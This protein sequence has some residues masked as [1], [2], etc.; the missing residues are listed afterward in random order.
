VSRPVARPSD[1]S[2]GPSAEHA[3]TILIPTYNRRRALEVVWPSYFTSAHVS[4][5]V[6]VDDGSDDGTADAARALAADAPVPVRVIAHG[7]RRGQQAAR[8]SAVAAARTEW[9]LF[10]EDDVWLEPDYLDTLVATARRQHADAVA[11]RLLTL[12][13]PEGFDPAAAVAAPGRWVAPHAFFDLERLEADFSATTD[14]PIAA[15]FLHSIA[16]IR[17]GLIEQV[18]FDHWYR[19]NGWREETDFYF[20]ATGAGARILFDPTTACH[21]LRGPIS[22][23]GGQRIARWRVEYYAWRNTHH[24]MRKHWTFLNRRYGMDGTPLGWTLRFFADRQRRQLRRVLRTGLRSS[25]QG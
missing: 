10:G 9:V 22:A 19:G 5:L 7:E 13:V 17:R 24:L 25:F 16:L 18:G 11:G 8:M 3:V 15:P 12:R 2:A 20:S 23:L 6:I 14:G 4:E 1:T 21:H